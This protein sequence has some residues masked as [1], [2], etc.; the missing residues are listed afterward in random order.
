LYHLCIDSG[1]NGL[2]DGSDDIACLDRLRLD[3]GA[4]SCWYSD[5]HC[6]KAGGPPFRAPSPQ[7]ESA[8]STAAPWSWLVVAMLGAVAA[9]AICE[10]W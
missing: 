2:V 1:N 10:R 5:T 8:A 9:A 4:S 3:D 7:A 6:C